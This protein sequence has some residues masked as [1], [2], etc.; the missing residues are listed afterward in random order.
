[1]ALNPQI[2]SR[3]LAVARKSL[4]LATHVGI[5]T[6]NRTFNRVDAALYLA[7][8]VVRVQGA[9]SRSYER[10]ITQVNQAIDQELERLKQ[11][12]TQSQN[13]IKAQLQRANVS[14]KKPEVAY[15][16]PNPV[17]LT[18]RT[19]KA[20][21]FIQLLEALEQTAQSIDAAWY[22]GLLSDVEQLQR[23]DVLWRHFQRSCGVIEALA[24]GLVRRVQQNNS[25]VNSVYRDMLKSRTGWEP[26]TPTDDTDAAMEMTEQETQGLEATE[27][28]ASSLS[29]EPETKAAE[30]LH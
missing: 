1:M 22:A 27:A 28:L 24:R 11:N 9:A 5:K 30:A 13:R 19:P 25:T 23:A 18:V 6:Y 12:V 2:N 8:I 10:E 26:D 4:K 16:D 14:L 17:D 20:R 29:V 3:S 21:Q 7:Q 15:T